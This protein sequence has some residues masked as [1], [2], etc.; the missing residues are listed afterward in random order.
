[1][2]IVESVEVLEINIPTGDTVNTG[3]LTKG[4][5]DNKCVPFV[6]L[7]SPRNTDERFDVRF[8]RVTISGSTV[9]VTRTNGTVNTFIDVI[10]SIVEFTDECTVQTGEVTMGNG[11]LTIT[12]SPATNF[13]DLTKTFVYLNYTPTSPTDDFNDSLTTA[14]ITNTTTLTF[15]RRASGQQVFCRWYTV[16]CDATQFDVQRGSFLL[17]GTLNESQSAAF[18]AVDLAR[19]MTIGNFNTTE[20][21]DDVETGNCTIDLV[22]TTHVRARRANGTT[23]QLGEIDI[24]FQVIQFESAEN[25]FVQRGEFVIPGIEDTNII[26]AV[27]TDVSMAH[28]PSGQNNA[29][30]NSTNGDDIGSIFC[31]M[32]IQDSTTVRGRIV[33]GTGPTGVHSWEVIEWIGAVPPVG[34][35]V[36][37]VEKVIITIPIGDSSATAPITKG[38]NNA[39]CVPFAT[40]SVPTGSSSDWSH[41]LITVEVSGD[42]VTVTRDVAG[43]NEVPVDVTVFVV[44]YTDECIVQ[45]GEAVL[46]DGVLTTTETITS[47]I[48]NRAF[49]YSSFRTNDI[50]SSPRNSAPT[51]VLTN[52]T[53]LT[54]TRI[55]ASV[56]DVLTI[57]WYVVECDATQFEVQRS[58]FLFGL[59]ANEATSAAFTAVDMARTMTIA[60]YL[61]DQP[62]Q[63]APHTISC[64][65]DLS[66]TTTVRARRANGATPN[67]GAIDVAFQVIE[68]AVDQ[69]ITVQR[70]DFLLPSTETSSPTVDTITI[71]SVNLDGSLVHSPAVQWNVSV[72]NGVSANDGILFCEMDLVNATTIT[73]LYQE[74]GVE[75]ISAFEVIEYPVPEEERVFSTAITNISAMI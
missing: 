68:F 28:S 63:N 31:S 14:E 33:T 19:T 71:T 62:G 40:A 37:S 52:S 4:Q 24:D 9:T 65:V 56:G 1:M 43:I 51:T 8:V 5:V 26:T 13:T 54:F 44:E 67:S 25:I 27:D 7:R 12:D 46:P 38:Q 61:T 21:I 30:M 66:S 32:D 45:T 36:Q 17:D 55:N 29:S 39:Q 15:T 20:G 60:D 18:T 11:V 64:T 23:P 22:D 59:T 3:T 57:R 2:A 10:V 53:T 48:E 6:T 72:D 16:E 58:T 74:F 41:K 50:A 73:G 69:N 47:V 75:E 35:I 42:L 34:G 70:G 49:T